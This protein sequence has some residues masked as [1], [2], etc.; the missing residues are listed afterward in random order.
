MEFGKVFHFSV[1]QAEP[2]VRELGVRSR[3][4]GPW[5]RGWVSGGRVGPVLCAGP[6]GLSDSGPGTRSPPLAALL[7]EAA[8]GPS[9][10]CFPGWKPEDSEA[11]REVAGGPALA[12]GLRYRVR[13]W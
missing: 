9:L 5:P 10:C 8:A 6:R 11:A 7:V 13:V 3:C 12:S 4:P 2:K 1:T